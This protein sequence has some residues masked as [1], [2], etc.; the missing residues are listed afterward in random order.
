TP[1]LASGSTG[2]FASKEYLLLFSEKKLRGFLIYAWPDYNVLEI[3]RGGVSF[4]VVATESG[5]K[6][7]N[8]F[9]KAVDVEEVEAFGFSGC[10]GLASN[11][12]YIWSR[13]LPLLKKAIFV[14]YGPDTFAAHFP[15]HDY[16]GK[17]RVW[18]SGIFTMI[19]K[20]HN[21]FLQV[22]INSGL[23]SLLAILVLFAVYLYESICLYW[24][25]CFCRASEI[26]GLGLM[27]AVVAYLVAAMFNDSI[28]GIAPVFWGV[29][30]MGIAA[31]R[32]NLGAMNDERK[33][34]NESNRAD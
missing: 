4:Y 1:G 20:P 33:I 25:C 19:E 24:R 12:G 22:G 18:G 13:T 21:L 30:G 2:F 8:Q 14:G 15:N 27:A 6:M 31:N 32:I 26:V 28:V 7:L 23:I 34:W 29:L 11:R 5:F 17:L 10:Q 9:G 16:L 3:G